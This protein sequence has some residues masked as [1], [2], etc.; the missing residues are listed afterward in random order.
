MTDP[1]SPLVQDLQS[2]NEVK[3]AARDYPSIFD[4][5][6]R[7]L[8]IEYENVYNDYATTSQGIMLVE[9]MAYA[10]GMLQWYLDRT[11]SDSFLE[12]ARTK[13]AVARLVKQIGYK[14]GAASASST[15]LTLTF[16][17][18]T[19]GPF[20]M[21]ARWQYQGPDGLIFESYAE[22]SQPIALG[23]GATISV[24][25]RQGETKLLTYTSNGTKNQ[26]YR[27][28]SIDDGRY[29]ADGTVD[30]WVDGLLWTENDFLEFEK[31]NQYE[32]GY[33]DD[34]PTVQFGDGIA[35]NI[36]PEGAEIK[37]RFL[38]IDGESGNVNINSITTSIDTL[39][40]GGEQVDFTVTN[41]TVVSG[42]QGPE[43]P[44]RAKRLAPFSFAARGATITK[45]DYEALSS[46]YTDP[47]YGAVAVS[48]A[49]N[50]RNAYEDVV[51]N[52][53]ISGIEAYLT[54]Y[55]NGGSTFSGMIAMEAAINQTATDLS[56]LI[57]SLN[58]DLSNLNLLKADLTSQ[59][60]TAI[61][62]NTTAMNSSSDAQSSATVAISN[63]T[64][65]DTE[66]DDLITYVNGLGSLSAPEKTEIIR[67]INLAIGDV[68]LAGTNTTSAQTAAGASANALSTSIYD[69]LNP[70]YESITVAATVPD[71]SLPSIIVDMT[72][73]LASITDEVEGSSGLQ[74]QISDMVGEAQTLQGL[75]LV[76]LISMH[77]RIGELFNTDCMSNYVQVPIMSL[78]ADGNYAAPSIGLLNGLQ[79]YL[80]GTKEVT[81]NVEVIDGSSI[82]VPAVIG[83]VLKVN[84]DAY[85]ESEIVSD[86]V[87]T[88]V[89]MLKGRSFDQPLYLSDL[90]ENVKG[91]SAGIVRVN[92]DI[93]GPAAELDVDGNLV[94]DSN[95]IIVFGSL[96]IVDENGSTLY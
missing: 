67:R 13:D 85:V 26:Q 52:G 82:L 89:G 5:L 69:N 53:L 91:T 8:K 19:S 29:L 2:L 39:L 78:D 59:V 30:V 16:A 38:I 34:P 61:V 10:L 4:S 81:Q 37:I 40:I 73:D 80:D 46:S 41:L 96:S 54:E 12:T 17:D 43:D 51:F 57:A 21:P 50:P 36:P 95:K 20:V 63:C 1:Y 7:R 83:I 66:L 27:L 14:M 84:K 79:E 44:E 18:G 35:G 68:S 87:A 25:V 94:P 6:L 92:V 28:S 32:V 15:T 31:T 64:D 47:T 93:T 58:S 74:S 42:G 77:D 9:L 3:Y 23:A 11:A 45:G 56:L 90:Y 49:F 76:D 71:Y 48:S 60:G 70:A 62:Q 65:A 75:I 88:V 33:N 55:L 24:P 86:I 72:A 22:Y